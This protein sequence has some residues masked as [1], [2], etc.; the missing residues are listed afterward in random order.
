[1]N[2]WNKEIKDIERELKTD[3]ENGL[4][5]EEI[6]NKKIE[7]GT[8][9]LKGKKKQNII[10]KFLNEFKDFMIIVLIIAAIVSGYIGIKE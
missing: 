7:Y 9:E 8:N 1:M 6:E 2:Y 4:K 10:V 3:L 5:A